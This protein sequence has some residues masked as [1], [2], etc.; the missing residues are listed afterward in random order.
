M[1]FTAIH[2]FGIIGL[3]GSD[4]MTQK[5]Y[6]VWN[7]AHNEGIVLDN[8]DDVHTA[9]TGE[10]DGSCSTLAEKFSR[11]YDDDKKTVEEYG[12]ELHLCQLSQ[13]ALLQ[14]VKR[15]KKFAKSRLEKIKRLTTV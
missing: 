12:T 14:E 8:T 10:H 3:K 5:Y 1:V 15:L 6:I 9:M 4:D 7:E 13:A 11:L 2:M